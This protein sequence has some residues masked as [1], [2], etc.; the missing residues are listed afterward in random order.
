MII[1]LQLAAYFY[2]K[3]NKSDMDY[4]PDMI[5]QQCER[6]LTKLC[7][8]TNAKNYGLHI[9]MCN[10]DC[11]EYLRRKYKTEFCRSDIAATTIRN[12]FNMFK[13]I[14]NRGDYDKL[15]QIPLRNII[16]SNDDRLYFYLK[17]RGVSRNDY[18]NILLDN[19][20]LNSCETVLTDIIDNTS[21][22]KHTKRYIPDV[23][24]YLLYKN[25]DMGIRFYNQYKDNILVNLNSIIRLCSTD[26]MIYFIKELGFVNDLTPDSLYIAVETGSVSKIRY[27]REILDSNDNDDTKDNDYNDQYFIDIHDEISNIMWSNHNTD[28]N[29]D[30]NTDYNTDYNIDHNID[31]NT[32]IRSKTKNYIDKSID[33]AIDNNNKLCMEYLLSR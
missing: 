26:L 7:V 29:T 21:F 17:E 23:F 22:T 4:L 28:H 15:S 3:N 31:N 16:F 6:Q 32:A 11:V 9:R 25:T 5:K 13:Y 2:V 27:I 30:N 19:E 24:Y 20:H 1:S 18:I 10:L 33:I 14:A 8:N 12:D